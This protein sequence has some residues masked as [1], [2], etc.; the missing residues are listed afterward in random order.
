M[1]IKTDEEHE[2]IWQDIKRLILDL[3]EQGKTMR[4]I[5]RE[6]FGYTGGY[7]HASVQQVIDEAKGKG[8]GN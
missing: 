2:K 5:E 3:H 1:T 7:A 8:D 4:E 6:V